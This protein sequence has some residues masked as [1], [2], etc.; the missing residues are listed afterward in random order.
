MAGKNMNW[1]NIS[2]TDIGSIPI[3]DDM[4][5]RDPSKP[6]HGG[7]KPCRAMCF[8]GGYPGEFLLRL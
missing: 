6:F 1:T 5:Y 3:V 2:K 8:I 4:K 7:G